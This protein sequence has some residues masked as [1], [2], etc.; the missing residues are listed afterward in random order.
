MG[1]CQTK[2]IGD[3]FQGGSAG[4]SSIWIRD[5]GA[6]PTHGTGPGKHLEQIHQ[7]DNGEAAKET[8]GWSIGVPTTGESNGGGGS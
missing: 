6:D 3:L 4:G 1:W 2:G 5:V 7:A 8:V